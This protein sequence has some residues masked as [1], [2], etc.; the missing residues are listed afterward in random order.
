MPR[1]RKKRRIE[2]LAEA[3]EAADKAGL[4]LQAIDLRTCGADLR[5]VIRDARAIQR[6]LHDLTVQAMQLDLPEPPTGVA[7]P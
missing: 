6:Q 5:A 4:S 2:L 1:P 3:L 7:P